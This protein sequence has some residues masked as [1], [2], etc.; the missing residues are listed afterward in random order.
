MDTYIDIENADIDIKV[1]YVFMDFC[2]DYIV[3]ACINYSLIFIFLSLL[4]SQEVAEK[5]KTCL[6]AL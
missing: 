3:F 5:H 4:L 2:L 1:F 6:H